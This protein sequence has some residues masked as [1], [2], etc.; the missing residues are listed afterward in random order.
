VIVNEFLPYTKHHFEYALRLIQQSVYTPV[1]PLQITAWRTPEPVSFAQRQSGEKLELKV[2][3][4]WGS[5][6]DSAWFYFRGVV[7]KEATGKT[8][9]LL[10]DV[11]GEMC[12]FND[13]GIPVRGL[14]N[15]DSDYDKRLGL[16]GKR[17]LPFLE[18]AVGGEEV[19]VWAD[20]GCNDLF[21]RIQNNGT[22]Q[23]ASIAIME[24]ET[25]DLFYDFEVLLDSLKVLPEKTPRAAEISLALHQVTHI[26]WNGLTPSSVNQSR[27]HLAPIL[28]R[29]GGNSNLAISAVGHAH[30][31]LGWLWPIRETHRKGARTFATA[32]ANMDLYPDYIFAASQAQLFQWIKEDHPELYARIKH[33]VATGRLEPQGALWVECDTNVTGGESLVRQ[34]LYG[35]KFFRQEFGVDP[36]Y[37]W[38][39]DTFGYSAALP[40]LIRRSG[41]A[42]FSTQKLSW[43]L[44]NTFPHHS[45]HWQGIDGSQILVHMLPEETYNSPAAPR[46]IARIEENYAQ[47]AVSGHALMIYGIGDGGGGPGEEHLERLIRLKDFSG[48]SPVRQRWTAEFFEQWQAEAQNFPTWVGELYLER[49]QG[50]LTTS[51]RSKW[52]NRKM[53][54]SLRELEWLASVASTVSHI[55]YPSGDI[56]RIWKETLLYQFHDILPG[57]SIKRVY[58]ESLARYSILSSEV[59]QLTQQMENEIFSQVD[60][61]GLDNPIAIVNP[62]SWN[63]TAWVKHDQKW[64]SVQVPSM[65]YC[66]VD[67]EEIHEIPGSLTATKNNLENDKIL[68]QFNSDGTMSSIVYK[69]G[70]REI[71]PAEESANLL[72]VYRDHGD[73]WDIPLDYGSVK[74]ETMQ[75]VSSSAWIDGP[76]AILKQTYRY[77]YS[78]LVQE[79]SLTT[80]SSLIEFDTWLRWLE[81][82]TMLRVKFPSAIFAE[83]ASFEIQFGHVQRPTH[84]NTSWDLAKDEV[85]AHKWAD[86]S[87]R[88]FGVALINDSKYGHRVKGH[89]LELNLLRSV[90]YPGT[91]VVPDSA[92]IPGE[93]FHAYTDQ[94]EHRF[95]YV[96]YPHV[97]DLV[98]GE[99]IKAAYEFNIPLRIMPLQSKPGNQSSIKSFFSIDQ[100]NVIIE[101]VK[102]A[103][104]GEGIILRLYEAWRMRSKVILTIGFPIQSAAEV[105]LIEEDERVIHSVGNT[106]PLEFGP[107]EVK[108]VRLYSRPD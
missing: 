103:E 43:S 39:P 3:D 48:L 28:K 23:E 34:I 4:A 9:V 2:G 64:L 33:K 107:F 87:Q 60:A 16:P 45:F 76:K 101:T 13:Q 53:E 69:E 85:P 51:G 97:G 94:G 89:T 63:R 70:W 99:V 104:H 11:S 71:V 17:V 95:R 49:H 14:T 47:K 90:F 106:V 20:A 24:P 22:V 65:G 93:P 29:R 105:N 31:D 82:A 27:L 55:D 12:V 96:L 77:G 6:F 68:I 108:T 35:K 57:S 79:I 91:R 78:E 67:V 58:D 50:T 21:G 37:I 1:A 83:E 80:G 52:H 8:V 62:L 98:M 18:V 72:T 86:L 74:P 36:N 10:L 19:E 26:F 56:E 61:Q 46:S 32:L 102:K 41:M 84:T 7:P 54:Q 40:Q 38:L 92:Y 66:V 25:R 42:Y 44:I 15:A 5:L 73:A 88:D 75:L 30:I 100:P 59:S 81:P